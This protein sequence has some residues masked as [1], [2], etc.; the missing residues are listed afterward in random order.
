MLR[1]GGEESGSVGAEIE[2]IEAFGGKVAAVP[3]REGLPPGFRMRADAHYVEQLETTPGVV[4]R[5][6]EIDV[7]DAGT[8]APVAPAARLI[9]SVRT[10]GVLEPLLV[11]HDRRGQRYRLIAG[12]QRLAAARA[13]GLAQVPC[14]LYAV[15]DVQAAQYRSAT[16]AQPERVTPAASAAAD[17][18]RT[19]VERDLEAALNGIASA[20]ALLAGASRTIQDGA[21]QLVRIE[22]RRALRLLTALRVLGGELPVRR[23][24][25]G[26]LALVNRVAQT[27]QEEHRSLDV[28]HEVRVGTFPDVLL[29]GNHELLFTAICNAVAAI[30]VAV[31]P[32]QARCIELSAAADA[33]TRRAGITV[34]EGGL[35]VPRPWI[36]S[37]FERPW[38][39]EKGPTALVLLQAARNI[40]AWHGGTLTIASDEDATYVRIDVPLA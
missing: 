36:D 2:E 18:F 40:A 24:P 35:L 27:I 37:A 29:H 31:D 11:Q 21:V 34:R 8:A 23:S 26:A 7:I 4:L 32:D 38:P 33:S 6:L 10:H 19:P 22:S 25:T 17:V 16:Y 5:S 14:I 1:S 30:D 28:A 9:E 15:S 12:G 3:Q 20:A 39:V 13:A